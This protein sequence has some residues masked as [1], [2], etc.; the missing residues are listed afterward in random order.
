MT[1]DS[2]RDGEICDWEGERGG[3]S[4]EENDRVI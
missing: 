4:R 3:D 1:G 2:K